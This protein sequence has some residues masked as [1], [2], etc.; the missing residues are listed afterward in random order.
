MHYVLGV[1]NNINNNVMITTTMMMETKKQ[2][3]LSN[4]TDGHWTDGRHWPT[5]KTALT[6]SVA[7]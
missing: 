1:D 7:R 3:Q 4:V 2:T 6:H 5:A